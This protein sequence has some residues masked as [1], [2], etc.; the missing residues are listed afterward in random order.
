MGHEDVNITLRHY[1]NFEKVTPRSTHP[2]SAKDLGYRL[3]RTTHEGSVRFDR[4]VVLVALNPYRNPSVAVVGLPNYQIL[5]RV[6]LAL[7]KV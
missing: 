5:P 4:P 2:I 6:A 7:T 3:T 1:G